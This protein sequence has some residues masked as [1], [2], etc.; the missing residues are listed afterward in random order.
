MP[1][2]Q[3]ADDLLGDIGMVARARDVERR[4][5]EVARFAA[6]DR[7]SRHEYCLTRLRW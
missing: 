1:A 3:L 7:D 4:Q 5:R 2:A 6:I